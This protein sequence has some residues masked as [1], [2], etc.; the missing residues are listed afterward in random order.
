[1]HGKA[2]ALMTAICF[3]INPVLLKLGFARKGRSDVAVVIG[4]AIT[5]PVYLAIAPLVGG[6]S[7]AHMTLPAVVG[8]VLGGLFGGGIGRRWMY[9][10]IEK[11]GASPAAA[12]KNAAPVITTALAILFLGERV[13]LL[14]WLAI[15]T[16]VAGI[17]LI[18]WRKGLGARH[19]LSVGVLAALGS[20]LSYGIRPLFLKYGLDAAN[21]PLTG[22]LIGAVAALVYAAVLTPNSELWFGLREK[23]LGL[24]VASGILQ[25]LGFLALTFGLSGEDVSIVYPVTSTAPLFTLLFTALMLRN[26]E[27]L[28]WR[29]VV[30]AVA[31]TAGVIVL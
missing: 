31:I 20:A 21:L 9:L 25:A 19:M 7:F 18:T 30:G 14:H 17:T 4:L 15:V 2:L 10:A 27:R 24:F 3:G 28:T 11:I 13:T 29:I 12:I 26:T 16:I 23:S 1:M 8:F 22:A 5:V 6:I